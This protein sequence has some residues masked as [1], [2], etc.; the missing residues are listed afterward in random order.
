[1]K[2]FIIDNEIFNNYNDLN[3][4]VIVCKNIDNTK[5]NS[6][7]RELYNNISETIKTK[8]A[9]VE[10]S[11]YPI[12]RTWRDVYKSFGEKKA[13]SSVEALI[14]RVNNGNE[15]R[16]IN[17]LVDI[18]NYISLK[19]ELPCGGEN[20][21][22]IDGNLELT[23]A[24]GNEE[25]LPLGEPEKENP[26][27]N[28]IIYKFGDTVVCRNFNYRESDITKLTEDT[29]N[30]FLCIEDIMSNPDNLQSALKELEE[31]VLKY[32]GG[33]AVVYILNKYNQEIT[34]ED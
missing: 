7:I 23:F 21:D 13:R 10:L 17:P 11:E 22:K 18:Y 34:I 20:I 12:V 25:F 31:L 14:R 1:M 15:I 27:P 9:D 19:Y 33:I 5:A 2:K 8:F 24:T 29:T 4:G 30:A 28:E 32:L 16:E 26:N 3:I 6:E